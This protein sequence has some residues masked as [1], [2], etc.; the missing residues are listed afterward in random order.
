[1]P[2][3]YITNRPPENVNSLSLE[4]TYRVLEIDGTFTIEIAVIK[5]KGSILKKKYLE[6]IPCNIFG[7]AFIHM[8]SIGKANSCLKLKSF[9]TLDEAIDQIEKFK[10]PEIKLPKYHYYY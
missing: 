2:R 10:N 1:M 9:Q 5:N 6:W 8:I 4:G 3:K 7:T